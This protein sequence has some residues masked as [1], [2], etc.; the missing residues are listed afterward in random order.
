MKKFVTHLSNLVRET[1]GTRQ[2][3]H[4]TIKYHRMPYQVKQMIQTPENSE[5][6]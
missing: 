4:I 2:C 3:F 5:K 1:P 6:L